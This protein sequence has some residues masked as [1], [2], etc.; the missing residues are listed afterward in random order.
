MLLKLPCLLSKFSLP[1][2]GSAGGVAASRIRFRSLDV[3]DTGFYRCEASN[4]VD[5][6]SGESILKATVTKVDRVG[7]F[8]AA[9]DDD[10]FYDDDYDEHDESKLVPKVGT[11]E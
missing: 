1:K 8:H 5:T 2:A 10:Y 4:G 3:H 7:G 11:G 6:V 9:N